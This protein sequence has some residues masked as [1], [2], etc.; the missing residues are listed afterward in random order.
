MQGAV[1]TKFYTVAL[2]IRGSS[3]WNLVHATGMAG[4]ILRWLIDFGKFFHPW[5][6]V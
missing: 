2:N 1:V 6:G 4:R 5:Y 3:L